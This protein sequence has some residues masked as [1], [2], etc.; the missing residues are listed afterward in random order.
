MSLNRKKYIMTKAH[1]GFALPVAIFVITVLGLLIGSVAKMN[2]TTSVGFG[3]DLHSIYAF[4]AAE[5]GIDIALARVFPAG[6]TGAVTCDSSTYS[7]TSVEGLN[8]CDVAVECSTFSNG[9]DNY[10][11]FTSTASCGAGIDAAQRVIEVRA[12][13]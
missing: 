2:E 10:Y 5:S 1:R 13:N 9:S 6:G 11:T 7:S 3:Q 12:K 8:S 4:Y